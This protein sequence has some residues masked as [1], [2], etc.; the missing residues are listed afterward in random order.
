MFT[1]EK[2]RTCVFSRRNAFAGLCAL[3]IVL[4]WIAESHAQSNTNLP[5]RRFDS[6]RGFLLAGLTVQAF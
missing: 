6:Y 2:K 3:A 5:E 4:G 1:G